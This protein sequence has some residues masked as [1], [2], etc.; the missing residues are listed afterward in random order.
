MQ[1]ERLQSFIL[2][3]LL[4]PVPHDPNDDRTPLSYEGHC[5]FYQFLSRGAR[6]EA[7]LSCFACYSRVTYLVRIRSSRVSRV[8]CSVLWTSF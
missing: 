6:P 2:S 4:S 3:L 8:L 7:N 1:E 5:G